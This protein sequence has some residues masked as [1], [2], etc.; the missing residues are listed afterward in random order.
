MVSLRYVKNSCKPLFWFFAVF[1]F[2]ISVIGQFDKMLSWVLFVDQSPQQALLVSVAI[3]LFVAVGWATLLFFYWRNMINRTHKVIL[4]V[5]LCAEYIHL[6]GMLFMNLQSRLLLS[7]SFTSGPY[8]G[9]VSGLI[10][11]IYS[12]I[13][14]VWAVCLVVVACSKQTS[15]LLRKAAITL[16]IINLYLVLYMIAYPLIFGLIV[17]LD[18]GQFSLI[19]NGVSIIN[20]IAYSVGMIFFFGV[21]SFSKQ[22]SSVPLAPIA[23][24]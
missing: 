15:G 7:E 16:A 23:D 19:N 9:L 18:D 11:L 1:V 12:F 14:L 21:I 24:I 13:Y 20:A 4:S 3:S 2:I 17:E 22:K 5:L 10:Q 8:F 6:I